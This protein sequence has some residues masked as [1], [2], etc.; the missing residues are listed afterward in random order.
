M[1]NNQVKPIRVIESLPRPVSD[2]LLPRPTKHRSRLIFD[3]MLNTRS[4]QLTYNDEKRSYDRAVR[5]AE[6]AVDAQQLALTKVAADAEFSERQHKIS[7]LHETY[8]TQFSEIAQ[9]KQTELSVELAEERSLRLYEAEQDRKEAAKKAHQQAITRSHIAEFK[10]QNADLLARKED[11]VEQELAEEKR[12]QHEASKLQQIRDERATEDIRRRLEK[13]NLRSKVA[14]VAA[15]GY[16]E[17]IRQNAESEEMEGNSDFAKATFDSVLKMKEKQRELENDRHREWLTLQKEK[18][19]R[20]KEGK[21][22]VF[23]R[24]RNEVD[25]EEFDKRQR[26]M[27]SGRLQDYLKQQMEI[28]KEMEEREKRENRERDEE[29]L[30]ETQEKFER[31]MK[32]LEKLIPRDVGIEVPK[33]TVS[34]SITK[35]N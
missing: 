28:R 3:T 11:A 4:R 33:Y 9:R 15:R 17:R 12:I 16:E 18:E 19:A 6:Q 26:K 35:F 10:R 21:A 13:T 25:G 24:R 34:R 27:E 5:C 2:P 8:R 32:K 14:E 29:M 30:M 23:P 31:S 22:K 20:R 7:E 1:I